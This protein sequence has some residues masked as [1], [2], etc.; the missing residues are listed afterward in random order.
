MEKIRRHYIFLGQVQGVGFRWRA[1]KLARM[2]NLTGWVRNLWDGTVE[3][4]VQG[5]RED[6]REM[7]CRLQTQRFIHIEEIRE[8][9]MPPEE[10]NSFRAR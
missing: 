1:E 10:E 4:E 5:T 9:T 7:I 2:L 3:M 6:I 8:K